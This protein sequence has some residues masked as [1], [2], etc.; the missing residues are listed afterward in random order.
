MLAFNLMEALPEDT[1]RMFFGDFIPQEL[2]DF[3]NFAAFF[4]VN[5]SR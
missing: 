2:L 5:L 4:T 3:H 1:R